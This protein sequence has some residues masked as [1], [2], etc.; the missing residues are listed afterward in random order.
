MKMD[1]FQRQGRCSKLVA[2]PSFINAHRPQ[3]VSVSP[4]LSGFWVNRRVAT[5]SRDPSQF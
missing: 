5:T 2:A 1:G 3:R 4:A